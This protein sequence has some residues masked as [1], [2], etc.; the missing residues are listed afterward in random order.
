MTKRIDY[1][2]TSPKAIGILMQQ[3]SYLA[4]QFA[5][6]NS[7]NT[8]TWELVKL[9][10]SQINQCAYCIDMHYKH[11]VKLGEKTER[12]VGLS[13]WKDMP[14]YTDVEKSAFAWAEW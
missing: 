2:N 13:A 6:S 5:V 4:E 12:I 3:E 11:L 8:T 7:V 1:F 14:F 9:R 10:I